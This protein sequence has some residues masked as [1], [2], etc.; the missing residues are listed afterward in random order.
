MP[1]GSLCQSN[2]WPLYRAVNRSR[3]RDLV[4]DLEEQQMLVLVVPGPRAG[5]DRRHDDVARPLE[6]G[7]RSCPRKCVRSLTIG[8]PNVSP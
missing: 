2:H 1:P 4:V 6:L 7:P 8:P 5:G 3:W